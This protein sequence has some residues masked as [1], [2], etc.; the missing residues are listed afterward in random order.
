MAQKYCKV[1][2]AVSI[3]NRKSQ[4]VDPI[5]VEEAV[6]FFDGELTTVLQNVEDA[7]RSLPCTDGNYTKANI[8]DSLCTLYDLQRIPQA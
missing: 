6:N 5:E 4:V 2:V 7:I 1:Q 8:I 3:G